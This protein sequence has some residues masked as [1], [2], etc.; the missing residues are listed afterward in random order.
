MNYEVL[1]EG[2]GLMACIYDA[3]AGVGRAPDERQ[4]FKDLLKSRN[5]D[6]YVCNK[7]VY[8]ITT[9]KYD[10]LFKNLGLLK[11]VNKKIYFKTAQGEMILVTRQNFSVRCYLKEPE[12]CPE[13]W[14]QIYV[15]K[16]KS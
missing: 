11:K 6:Y 5:I 16:P 1:T 13:A 7:S 9:D 3:K 12:C 4:I 15:R 14:V 8:L 10:I 2:T